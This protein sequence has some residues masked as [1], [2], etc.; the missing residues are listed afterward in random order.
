M[1]K[2]VFHTLFEKCSSV[3]SFVV[4]I[5]CERFYYLFFSSI[6]VIVLS[7]V[8]TNFYFLVKYYLPH[9]EKSH[10]EEHNQIN[11][12]DNYV[13]IIFYAYHCLFHSYTVYIQQSLFVDQVLGCSTD[14]HD[15]VT[16][17]WSLFENVLLIPTFITVNSLIWFL[18]RCDTSFVALMNTMSLS[19]IW[20]FYLNCVTV[21]FILKNLSSLYQLANIFVLCNIFI[22]GWHRLK[23]K[24]VNPKTIIICINIDFNLSIKLMLLKI[25]IIFNIVSS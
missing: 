19:R 21:I 11:Q 6:V 16:E 2:T 18:W 10:L 25:W 7:L 13:S 1:V 24:S 20:L 14:I 12:K 5:R 9:L 8:C 23:N 3:K 4:S 15:R 17:K 22:F